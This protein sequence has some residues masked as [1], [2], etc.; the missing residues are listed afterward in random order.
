MTVSGD[1]DAFFITIQCCSLVSATQV[2]QHSH[3]GAAASSLLIKNFWYANLKT[4]AA[5]LSPMGRSL[6]HAEA[7]LCRLQATVNRW[8]LITGS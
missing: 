1:E 3:R 5:L 7:S 2:Y 8:L 4:P 6:K